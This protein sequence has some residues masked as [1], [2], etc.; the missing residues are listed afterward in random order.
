VRRPRSVPCGI[1]VFRTL[2]AAAAA[3]EDDGCR[4]VARINRNRRATLTG[5]GEFVG[6]GQSRPHALQLN[7]DFNPAHPPGHSRS[8]RVAAAPRGFYIDLFAVAM[9][10]H[11][12]DASDVTRVHARVPR[13]RS[14]MR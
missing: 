10:G 14:P 12:K 2:Q 6:A 8:A 11:P 13:P 7:R 9:D 5:F 3:G 4:D 1:T